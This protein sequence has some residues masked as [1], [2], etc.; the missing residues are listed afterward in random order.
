MTKFQTA[1]ARVKYQVPA[2]SCVWAIFKNP[3]ALLAILRALA[4]LRS[5]G[6]AR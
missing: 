2:L 5:K 4:S 6:A 1:L 3:L